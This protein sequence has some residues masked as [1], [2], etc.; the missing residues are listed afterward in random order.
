M[1]GTWAFCTDRCYELINLSGKKRLMQI[2][3][4]EFN[5][6]QQS[7]LLASSNVWQMRSVLCSQTISSALELSTLRGLLNTCCEG[8]RASHLPVR[9]EARGEGR[10]A[11]Y[12][13]SQPPCGLLELTRTLARTPVLLPG[14]VDTVSLA[15]VG[16][17]REPW[18][19]APLP[20]FPAKCSVP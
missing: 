2:G 8:R 6:R 4:E 14:S 20:S 18:P 19:K 5:G 10:E 11:P 1:G 16:H 12:S 13:P 9:A 17:K 3:A 15:A 7:D